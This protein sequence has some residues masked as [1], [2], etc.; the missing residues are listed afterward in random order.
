MF[1]QLALFFVLLR[2]AS[3]D[4]TNGEC[5][6]TPCVRE[7]APCCDTEQFCHAGEFCSAG[8]CNA[9]MS[10][11]KTCANLT[12]IAKALPMLT[13]LASNTSTSSAALIAQH[14]LLNC[15]PP[16]NHAEP[17]VQSLAPFKILY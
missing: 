5:K 12:L 10:L 11:D 16:C 15:F 17:P 2:S 7:D 13:L 6:V 4:I 9:T 8:E 14:S 1:L 3:A